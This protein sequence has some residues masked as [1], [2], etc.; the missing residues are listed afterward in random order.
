[1]LKFP[2]RNVRPFC[3]PAFPLDEAR[4]N[5]ELKAPA[6]LLALEPLQ[7]LLQQVPEPPP[8]LLDQALAAGL[9]SKDAPILAAAAACCP[10]WLAT[11]DRRDCGHLCGQRARGVLL[12]AP[13]EALAALLD[14][15]E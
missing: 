12:L 3:I 11:G 5:L 4:R 7:T 13:R 10:D 15:V 6:R 8:E 1:L 2:F 14:T 9:P